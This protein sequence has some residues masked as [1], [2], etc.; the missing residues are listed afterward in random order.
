MK[1]GLISWNDYSFNFKEVD[2][3][4]KLWNKMGGGTSYPVMG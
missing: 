4:W 2:I 1:W 3:D